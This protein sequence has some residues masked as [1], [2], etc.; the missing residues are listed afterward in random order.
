MATLTIETSRMTMNCARQQTVSSSAWRGRASCP[1]GACA[2]AR[3]G[4]MGAA[5]EVTSAALGR[6]SG[7]DD[8]HGGRGGEQF[9]ARSQR[10]HGHVRVGVRDCLLY[11]S[12][13]ADEEDSV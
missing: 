13:A 11:T 4:V 7:L 8:G 12:D 10:L 6:S 2:A 5:A 1:A 9:A 3:R